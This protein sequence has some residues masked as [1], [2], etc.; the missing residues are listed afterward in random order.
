MAQLIEQ[1]LVARI[2]A[3]PEVVALLGTATGSTSPAIFKSGVPQTYDYGVNGPALTYSFPDKPMGHV[4]TGSDGTAAGTAELVV[5]SYSYGTSKVII[6]KLFN[7]LD[8]PPVE[9]SWGDGSCEI[10]TVTSQGDSDIPIPPKAGTDQ[11]IYAIMTMYRIQ[12]RVTI[13]TLS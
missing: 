8:G 12:Y 9:T 3:I 5:S 13:P 11:W 10:I 2:K 6:E 1:A 7:G 4:L